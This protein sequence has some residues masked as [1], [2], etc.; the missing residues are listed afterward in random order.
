MD[1]LEP[2]QE[3]GAGET[4]GWIGTYPSNG[5]W[6]PHLHFQVMTDMLDYQGDFPGVARPSEAWYW[7]GLCIDP[8][9]MLGLD[10][11]VDAAQ[12]DPRH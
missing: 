3:V 7:R 1:H 6:P 9:L 8:N 12:D 2:G 11:P 10:L 5:N 4:I